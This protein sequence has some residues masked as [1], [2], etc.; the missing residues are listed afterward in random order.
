MQIP[1]KRTTNLKTN[2]YIRFEFND[3]PIY[4]DPKYPNW[5]AVNPLGD[6]ILKKI[7]NGDKTQNNINCPEKN[8]N[9]LDAFHQKKLM[10]SI[11]I[12]PYETY[13]GR[14][15]YIQLSHLDECWLH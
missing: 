14:S 8:L 11:P 3:I 6:T 13:K 5:I 7:F 4:I 9:I 15:E 2:N 12:A 10:D 1:E